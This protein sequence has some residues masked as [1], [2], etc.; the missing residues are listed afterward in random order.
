MEEEGNH[1][2]DIG[3]SVAAARD[4]IRPRKRTSLKLIW[5]VSRLRWFGRAERRRKDNLHWKDS[6]KF[7]DDGHEKT[8]KNKIDMDSYNDKRRLREKLE[9]N[10][11]SNK[12]MMDP[13]NME[14]T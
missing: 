4:G 10:G 7:R 13:Y 11:N 8:R 14:K 3:F 12:E 9:D 1:P 5:N 2:R 6:K